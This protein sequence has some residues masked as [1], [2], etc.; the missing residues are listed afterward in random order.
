SLLAPGRKHVPCRS[1]V[2]TSRLADRGF[3]EHSPQ[4]L[5]EELVLLR[6]ADRHADRACC[7]EPARRADDHSLAEELLEERARV[8]ADLGEQE[9][10]DRAGRIEAVLPQDALELD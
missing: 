10:R 4:R 2:S 8:L 1:S 5:A 7:A 9:V 3:A 6:R